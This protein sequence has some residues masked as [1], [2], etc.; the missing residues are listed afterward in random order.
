MRA[1][2]VMFDSLRLDLLPNYG[3]DCAALPNFARLAERTVTFDRNFVGSLPC[4]PA[5]RELHTGRLNFLHAPWCPLEPF[6][7]SMPELLRESGVHTH[8]C[9]DHYHYIQDGAQRTTAATP[10]MRFSAGR[11]ATAGSATARPSKRFR[12]TC[13][14]ARIC[15]KATAWAAWPTARRTTRTARCSAQRPTTRRP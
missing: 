11:S 5:R 4:M 2:M 6:D 7:D 8:L 14:A 13:S 15:R 1:V 10:R 12:R 9:T 3:A